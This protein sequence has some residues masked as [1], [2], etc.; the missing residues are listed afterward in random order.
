MIAYL[1]SSAFLKLVREEEESGALQRELEAWP[2][3]ASSSLLRVEVLRVARAAGQ[4][5]LTR[6]AELLADVALLPVSESRL[7]A[8]VDV[9]PPLVRSLDA[10]HVATAVSIGDELG[11]LITYDRRMLGAAAAAGIQALAPGS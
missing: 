4:L 3:R 1:D 5:E 2:D 7:G 6:A 8:A 9:E 11:A 10:I